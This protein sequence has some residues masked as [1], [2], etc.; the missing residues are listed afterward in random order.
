[1]LSLST[2]FRRAGM[3]VAA[4]FWL[5]LALR[6]P[7]PA[8]ELDFHA[9][10]P[11]VVA[12][13]GVDVVA[14]EAAL[15]AA[16]EAA[17]VAGQAP[18]LELA[19]DIRLTAPL[20]ALDN[21]RGGVLT[22]A[23]NGHSL[24]GQGVG[25]VLAIGPG[26]V[27]MVD[28]LTI[29]GGVGECG[30]GVYNEGLLTLQHSEVRDNQAHLGGGVC[31][32]SATQ[33]ARLTLLDSTVAGNAASEGGGLYALASGTD[34][35]SVAASVVIT[36]TRLTLQDNQADNGGG[37]VGAAG[38]NA[39]VGLYI[40][41]SLLTGNRATLHGG[42]LLSQTIKGAIHTI[43][44]RSALTFNEAA[45]GGAIYN[46][47]TTGIEW[48]EGGRATLDVINS[49]LSGNIASSGGAIFNYQ[50][51]LPFPPLRLAQVPPPYGGA[52]ASVAYSTL[53]ANAADEGSGVWNGGRLSLLST[54]IAGNAAA[55]GDCH[56]ANY[57]YSSGHNL[58]GDN[59]CGLDQSSDLPGGLVDLLPLT[60]NPPGT[61]PTHALGPASQARDHIPLD[62]GGCSVW[63]PNP[64]QRG[65]E[66]PQPF[67]GWCDIGAYEADN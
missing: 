66:R 21:P 44:Q 42:A 59:S 35:S 32:H 13:P 28:G 14:D 10:L 45:A 53:T 47:G 63:T 34:D 3:A 55:G 29:R 16:I 20:P 7:S 24:D 26:T 48:Y 38:Q 1:M 30:G 60:L 8:A 2:F 23:G 11:L 61:T 50:S 37:V 51:E 36:A 52:F 19:A 25:P 62:E 56:D 65:V 5:L 41:N 18:R 67:H 39:Y 27:I 43:V 17:N 22:L 31:V 12:A 33:T 9:I 4:T 64:D 15:R 46:E 40:E 6:A 54:I 57:L 49:T 58:D